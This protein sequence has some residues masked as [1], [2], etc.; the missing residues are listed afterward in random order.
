MF[1]KK[2]IIYLN[3]YVVPTS[4]F[5][6]ALLYFVVTMFGR[7]VYGILGDIGPFY[8]GNICH[9][10]YMIWDIHWDSGYGISKIIW[11]Y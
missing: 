7:L 5:C 6:V 9:F 4:Y 3:S 11:E 1:C 2:C 8:L 10:Y